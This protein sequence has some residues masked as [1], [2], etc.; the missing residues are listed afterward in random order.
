MSSWKLESSI[1]KKN[2]NGTIEVYKVGLDCVVSLLQ[3]GG[4]RIKDGSRVLA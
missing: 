2:G 1:T 4:Y 3:S